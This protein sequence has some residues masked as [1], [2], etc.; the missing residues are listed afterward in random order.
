[1]TPAG[2]DLI[3]YALNHYP[4]SVPADPAVG[5]TGP[6]VILASPARRGVC[7]RPALIAFIIPEQIRLHGC[8]IIIEAHWMG[9]TFVTDCASCSP[10]ALHL[11]SRGRSCRRILSYTT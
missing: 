8:F 4:H 9:F 6:M 11:P 7:Q 10:A 3:P 2:G 5:L 1:M